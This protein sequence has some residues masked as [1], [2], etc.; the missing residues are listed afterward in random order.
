MVL[1]SDL[2]FNV[3]LLFVDIGLTVWW[4]RDRSWASAVM[5][6][7]GAAFFALTLA[8]ALFLF[9]I[10][11]PFYLIRLAAYAVF[12]HAPLLLVGLA[13][14]HRS[15]RRVAAGLVG[16]AALI[17][18]IGID[19]F[20]IEPRWLATR[21]VVL[22]SAKVPEPL[23]IVV[24]ADLQ[25]DNFGGYERDVLRRAM[26]EQPDLLLLPGDYVHTD[27]PEA[28]ASEGSKLNAMLRE[29]GF[30]ARLGAYAVEGNC[31]AAGGWRWLFA[32]TEVTAWGASGTRAIAPWLHLTGLTLADS[33]DPTISIPPVAGFH[34]AM[35]HG[36]DFALGDVAADLLIAGHTHGGQVQI[37]FFGPIL[38]LSGVPRAWAH[39]VTDLA[40]GR[41]LVVSRGIGMERGRAP[42]LRFWCRPELVVIDVV[43]AEAGG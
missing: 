33:F 3:G 21:R 38:T 4:S 27:D 10:L 25:S 39:G 30:R 8:V 34:I 1:L 15:S 18:L 16:G 40:G 42:R 35:G 6:L 5:G 23:R 14:A 43:P 19:A 32:G 24:L 26:A 22:E 13:R 29:V 41:K 36:P 20:L 11:D 2:V 9:A 28:S 7:T 12:L 17:V 37:P 31:E